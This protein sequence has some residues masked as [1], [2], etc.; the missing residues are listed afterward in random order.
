MSDELMNKMNRVKRTDGP[1]LS[2]GKKDKKKEDK[3]AAPAW[4]KT[5]L[6]KGST[7]PWADDK[8]KEADKKP[9]WS[10]R[11]AL[12]KTEKKEIGELGEIK[13]QDWRDGLKKAG[14]K[15]PGEVNDSSGGDPEWKSVNLRST[16]RKDEDEEWTKICIQPLGS[17][18]LYRTLKSII[19]F[20][21]QFFLFCNKFCFCTNFVRSSAVFT[22]SVCFAV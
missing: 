20:I 9:D 13:R 10:G 2:V 5:Q 1:L 16:G 7:K 22:L 19:K 6:K 15:S 18:F 14:P 3:E 21:V 11:V 12:K 8:K 4:A 17:C